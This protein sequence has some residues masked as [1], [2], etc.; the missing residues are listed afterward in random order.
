MKIIPAID[1]L[2]GKVSR[3]TKGDFEKRI[4]YL[5]NALDY[6]LKYED[7]GFNILHIVDLEA[8]VSG[9]ITVYDILEEIKLKTKLKI[10]FGGGIK[11]VNTARRLTDCG[12]DK[13][14]IGSISVTDKSEFQKVIDEIS[15][16]KIIIAADVKENMIAING[17]KEV[18]NIH[19]NEH[20]KYCL[21]KRINNYLCT[22][23]TKDGMLKGTNLKL[24]NE[25]LHTFPDIN[26][27][28]SGGVSSVNDLIK[29]ENI[30]VGSV[31]VGKAI[32]E[33]KITLQELKKYA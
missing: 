31:V 9:N 26:L 2:N 11:K 21:N 8:S 17:W 15:V 16:D 27:I 28:A 4:E 1:L 33:N 3:L 32:Y 20:I 30:N 24:Y 12:V 22:D 18:S 29:L 19:I 23:I 13:L 7:L 25:L 6:A 10:Q 14:I 5:G